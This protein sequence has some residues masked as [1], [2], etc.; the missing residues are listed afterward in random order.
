MVS[1][2]S[3][4]HIREKPDQPSRDITVAF[5]ICGSDIV[6]GLAFCSSKD[7]FD[8]KFGRK[9]A[10]GRLTERIENPDKDPNFYTSGIIHNFDGSLYDPKTEIAGV[11]N[12]LL[13]SGQCPGEFKNMTATLELNGLANANPSIKSR[14]CDS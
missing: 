2:V 8:K 3:Y 12:S 10:V 13:Q 1:K 6:Y 11:L 4:M 9:I 14:A 7:N 5:K